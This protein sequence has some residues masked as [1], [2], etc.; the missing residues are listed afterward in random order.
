M[1]AT[2]IILLER[3]EKLGNLG[4]VVAVKPGYARNYLLPQKKA[5]RATKSNLAYFEA[6]RKSLEAEND[7]RKD[8]ASKRAKKLEGLTVPIIRQASE[9]G[10]LYG[11]VTARDIAE[12]ISTLADEKIE[13][14]MVELNQN[15][16]TIGLFPVPVRLH[17]EVKVDVTVNVARSND[18]A[19]IQQKTGKALIA[20]AGGIVETS[21]V[22]EEP[23][24]TEEKLQDVLEEEAYAAEKAAREAEEAEKAAAE[25]EAETQ[26]AE[27]GVEAHS[28]TGS[29]EETSEDATE[30]DTEKA[31]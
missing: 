28:A 4:D 30:E 18:E 7:K 22:E 23:E 26:S 6:Q 5:L 21:T 2:Q 27:N 15:F 10:Q 29:S 17:P 20:D 13:R 11:S 3:I 16:K 8:D 9:G 14:G 19:A 1:P 24:S 12:E 31:S 25:A